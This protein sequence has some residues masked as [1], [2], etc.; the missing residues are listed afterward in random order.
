MVFNILVTNDDDHLRNH[1]FLYDEND[2]G[3]R[4]SPLYD[5]MPKPQ[6]TQERM[7]YLSVGPQ[8]RVAR[9]DNA[10]AGAGRF[11]LPPPDA[12]AIVDRVVRA[13]RSW[14]DTFERLGIS[15]R[16]CD[17][18]ASAFRR[19]GDIGMREVER[20][21]RKPVEEQGQRRVEATQAV[22]TFAKKLAA[23]AWAWWCDEGLPAAAKDGLQ[24]A[25]DAAD[26][27]K[28]A[29]AAEVDGIKATLGEVEDC[30]ARL[31][32]FGVRATNAIAAD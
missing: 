11:G 14:R 15:A 10:L 29:L 31:R 27:V 16:D 7:L 6:A 8:G 24:A 13:V 23:D 21:L 22:E 26:D 25:Q 5:V 19:A 2:E 12:A 30:L 4:L 17:R 1:A 3:W 32:L 28:N 18:V 9:L 20:H